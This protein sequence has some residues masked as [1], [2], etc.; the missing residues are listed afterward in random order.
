MNIWMKKDTDK[1]AI[2]AIDSKQILATA[3]KFP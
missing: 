3:S 1:T 2:Y